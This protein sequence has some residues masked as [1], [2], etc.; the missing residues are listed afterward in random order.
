MLVHFKTG[1]DEDVVI[2]ATLVRTVTAHQQGTTRINFDKSHWVIVTGT[3]ADVLRKLRRAIAATEV[4]PSASVAT[5]RQPERAS[6]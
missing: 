2:N 3:V 1:Q 4:A 6:A 5:L